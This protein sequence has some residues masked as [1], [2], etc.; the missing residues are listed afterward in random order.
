MSVARIDGLWSAPGQYPSEAATYTKRI[1]AYKDISS[2]ASPKGIPAS[3][4]GGCFDERGVGIEVD[5]FFA[6]AGLC[7]RN[8][9]II[10]R[11]N[12]WSTR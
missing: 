11:L 5:E 4:G 6:R 12:M 1:I 2:S 9:A 7:C 3:D 8:A 10:D